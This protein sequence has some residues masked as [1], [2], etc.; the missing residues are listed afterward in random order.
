MKE[1]N[2]MKRPRYNIYKKYCYFRLKISKLVVNFM[3]ETSMLKKHMI[4]IG[5]SFFTHNQVVTTKFRI[6]PI[7][8]II[9]KLYLIGRKMIIPIPMI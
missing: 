2:S 9:E 8:E 5:I 1:I 3:G 7:G 4:V 6:R